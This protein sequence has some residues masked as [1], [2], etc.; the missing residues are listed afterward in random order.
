MKKNK[1][2]LELA[3]GELLISLVVLGGFAVA[4]I[5]LDI[6]YW[7]VVLGA[8]LGSAVTVLNFFF[9]SLSVNRSVDKYLELRGNVEMTDE[10]AAQFTA[11]HS[12]Q[13]Q[14]AI[15][16]SFIIRIITMLASLVAAFLL[17]NVFNP[18]A[19]AIPLL[20]YR[21]ILMAGEI[22][23]MKHNKIPNPENFIV[24]ND[25]DEDSISEECEAP[26]ERS[27]EANQ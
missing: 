12:M 13:I 5:W 8:L 20:A 22:F 14:N 19:T 11:E 27:E 16:M 6:N 21:P 18:I 26:T 17:L 2:T 1:Q 4:D 10:Q 25:E 9:L 7:S 15:K 3:L 24:Y 23:R